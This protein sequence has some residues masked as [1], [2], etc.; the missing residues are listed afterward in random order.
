MKTS[1]FFIPAKFLFFPFL[2]PTK[3]IEFTAEEVENASQLEPALEGLLR[4]QNLLEEIIM[5]Y[6]CNEVLSRSVFVTLN[7]SMEG[8]TKTA[9]TFGAKVESVEFIHKRGMAKLISAW[10]QDKVEHDTKQK[11]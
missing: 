2:M 6:R 4:S 8:L 9:A 5:A 1:A 10:Q 11:N 3:F 7:T